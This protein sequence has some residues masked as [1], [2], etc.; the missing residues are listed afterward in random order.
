MSPNF[1]E[2]C[3]SWV[4]LC[5]VTYRMPVRMIQIRY[6]GTCAK[7]KCCSIC[8]CTASTR[9]RTPHDCE[10]RFSR[11]LNVCVCVSKFKTW[12]TTDFSSFFVLT[13][14]GGL[15]HGFYFPFSWECRNPSWRTPSFFRRVGEKPP[16]SNQLVSSIYF[17]V[18]FFYPY[19][20]DHWTGSKTENHGEFL[21]S[22]HE[23]LP[24]PSH[25]HKEVVCLL[26]IPRKMGGKNGSVFPTSRF[27][28][29]I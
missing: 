23:F 11:M 8:L 21:P 4:M 14:V 13:L 28:W 6:S 24:S 22:N 12:G 18:D 16:T 17:V 26:T 25:H 1:T 10:R 19:S 15:E 9:R 20:L 5:W 29:K 3:N 27:P 7:S 2:Y